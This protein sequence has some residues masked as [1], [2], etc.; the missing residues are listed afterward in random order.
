M[1]VMDFKDQGYTQVPA[2]TRCMHTLCAPAKFML[3][4]QKHIAAFMSNESKT[5]TWKPSSISMIVQAMELGGAVTVWGDVAYDCSREG[6]PPVCPIRWF[7]TPIAKKLNTCGQLKPFHAHIIRACRAADAKAVGNGK[8]PKVMVELASGKAVELTPAVRE[9]LACTFYLRA[10]VQEAVICKAHG[11]LSKK[12]KNELDFADDDD[13]NKTRETEYIA[14]VHATAEAIASGAEDV[15]LHDAFGLEDH[16][17]KENPLP[18]VLEFFQMFNSQCGSVLSLQSKTKVWEVLVNCGLIQLWFGSF[19]RNPEDNNSADEEEGDQDAEADNSATHAA[20]GTAGTEEEKKAEKQK[21]ETVLPTTQEAQLALLGA[22]DGHLI[23]EDSSLPNIWTA[24]QEYWTSANSLAFMHSFYSLM[25]YTAEVLVLQ[26]T[27]EPTH[28]AVR[29][30]TTNELVR[31]EIRAAVMLRQTS[32]VPLLNA[33]LVL[34]KKKELK[35][36]YDF[37][38]SPEAMLARGVC[39]VVSACR[40]KGIHNI[41][42]LNLYNA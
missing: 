29:L 9:Y 25:Y 42:I 41:Q 18:K 34:G 11:G 1:M 8:P 12:I 22:V 13:E 4:V 37:K 31:D 5:K 38:T 16:F 30:F 15:V 14:K 40:S 10:A 33:Y 3:F 17:F 27:I 36:D 20:P 28:Q 7:A 6:S 21:K 32:L 19:A 39:V 35:P 26:G 23:H 24:P 2:Q